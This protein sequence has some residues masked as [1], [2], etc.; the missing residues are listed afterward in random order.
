MSTVPQFSMRELLEAG[1]HFGHKTRRW[2]PKMAPFIFGEKDGVHILN[3]QKTVPM[4]SA[5]LA[6]VHEVVSKNGRV[7]F[8]GTKPQAQDLIAEAAKRCGQHFINKR[9]LGGMLTNWQTVSNSIRTLRKQ[10]ETLADGGAGLKK[11]EKLE[12]ARSVEKLEKA[13]GGIKDIGG[14]PDLLFIIDTNKEALAI[15]EA[16]KLGIPVIAI[17]D[18]NCDPD[19]IDYP[20]PGNDDSIRAIELYCRLFSDAVLSGISQALGASPAHSKPEAV[21]VE[22]PKAEEKAAEAPAAKKAKEEKPAVETV[23][24]KSRK[25]KADDASEEASEEE[26]P[27]AKK[28]KKA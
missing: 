1:V 24:K 12:M 17:C 6:K 4:L 9:W 20:V 7:V 27:A 16:K 26:K 11:K 18:S 28:T 5:A 8:V 25:K 19:P 22:L 2:N 10:S 14:L 23:V 3:L 13:I 15:A 21:V